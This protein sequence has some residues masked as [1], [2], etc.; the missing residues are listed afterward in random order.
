MSIWQVYISMGF[1]VV[2]IN[3]RCD[4]LFPSP[5][6]VWNSLGW[7]HRSLIISSPNDWRWIHLGYID[8]NIPGN[9]G[10]LSHMP[11]VILYSLPIL[12]LQ[13]KDKNWKKKINETSN[14]SSRSETSSTVLVT[15]TEQELQVQF[16][17]VPLHMQK[18]C[19]RAC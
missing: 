1:H 5:W 8:G 4:H 10:F 9:V 2:W 3:V 19:Q 18:Q 11:L 6:M 14:F 12:Y 7:L 16:G 13:E 15:Y 17:P